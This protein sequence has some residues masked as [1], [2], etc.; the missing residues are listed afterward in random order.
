MNNPSSI[1]RVITNS[2]NSF[3]NT[4]TLCTGLSNLD[5]LVV[6]VLKNLSGKQQLKNFITEIMINLIQDDFKTELRLNL[7]TSISNYEN[8]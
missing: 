7:A 2:L 8:L 5:K 1:D 4:S 6:T 3:Q